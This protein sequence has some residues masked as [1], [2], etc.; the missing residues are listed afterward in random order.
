MMAS[1]ATLAP[2]IF[3][4]TSARLPAQAAPAA[5]SKATFSFTLH[6]T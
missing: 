1:R 5:S 2:D 6:S 3:M 4:V